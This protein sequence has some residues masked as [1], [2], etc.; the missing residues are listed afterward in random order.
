M[1]VLLAVLILED[2]YSGVN[3][4]WYRNGWKEFDFL[5][6]IDRKL[7][8]SDYYDDNV[9]KYGVKCG[10]SLRFWEQREWI[11]GTDPYGWL[12]WYCRY[13]LG[14]R[15]ADDE[16]QINRYRKIIARFKGKAAKSPK[17]RQILLHWGYELVSDD[18]I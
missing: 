9:N 2:I 5:R 10:T 1:K 4:K 14:R 7:Y 15:C 3:G 18:V 16:R 12:Q 11:N 17:I 6:G 8:S 13:Y